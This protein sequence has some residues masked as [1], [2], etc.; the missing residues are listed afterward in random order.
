M[1]IRPIY[2][3]F[4]NK[5]SLFAAVNTAAET[6][7]I[8]CYASGLNLRGIPGLVRGPGIPPHRVGGRAHILGR[9]RWVDSPVWTTRAMESLRGASTGR[10]DSDLLTRMI[11]GAWISGPVAG[12]TATTPQ[13]GGKST[14]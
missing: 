13:P 6:C 7:I 9:T 2:H 5:K 10:H 3:Y 12:R 11:M 14:K 4:G 8:A 1:T